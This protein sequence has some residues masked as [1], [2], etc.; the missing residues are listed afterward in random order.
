MLNSSCEGA[1]SQ[2]TNCCGVINVLFCLMVT[3]KVLQVLVVPVLIQALIVGI[4]LDGKRFGIPRIELK[5]VQTMI[6]M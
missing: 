4:F 1:N 2:S 5:W 6:Y 3:V